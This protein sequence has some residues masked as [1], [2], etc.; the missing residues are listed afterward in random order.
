MFIRNILLV[1]ILLISSNFAYS[2]DGYKDIK[3]DMTIDEVLNL[4]KNNNATFYQVDKW[5]GQ[6]VNIKGLYKYD[7]NVLCMPE[8][9]SLLVDSIEV[10]V[11]DDNYRDKYFTLNY[12]GIDKFEALRE[13]LKNKY[14]LVKEP[15]DL[16]IDKYN[17]GQADPL[18]FEHVNDV[19]PKI[20]IS[21]SLKNYNHVNYIASVWY[22]HPRHTERFLSSLENSSDDDF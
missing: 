22:L 17:M 13:N 6:S 19:D 11:F 7:I 14:K 21:L 2:K 10:I 5:G 9:N 3:F 1:V 16:A 8:G 4:A 12:S 20:I 15:D 18:Y